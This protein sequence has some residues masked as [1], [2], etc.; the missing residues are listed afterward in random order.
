MGHQGTVAQLSVSA[1]GVPKLAVA[2]ARIGPL[3]LDGDGHHDMENHG[4]PERAVCLYAMEVIETLR[5][6]G[7]T[8]GPGCAG[9]NVTVQGLDWTAVT[10]GRRIRLGQDV[11]LEVTRYTTPCKKNAG[12]FAGGDFMRMS[13]KLHPGSS[14]VYAQVIAEGVVRPGDPVQLED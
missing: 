6:E 11:V 14:R 1:G 7:H 10:P 8:I 2:E 12:W 9:E 3:G 5:A 13:E 4:G